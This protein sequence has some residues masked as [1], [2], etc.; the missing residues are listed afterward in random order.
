[1]RCMRISCWMTK[2]TYTHSEYVILTHS[3][4]VHTNVPQCYVCTYISCLV[5]VN[6]GLLN[7]SKLRSVND[8]LMLHG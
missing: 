5:F 7:L 3:S 6:F 1:M 2:A 8:D 4:N